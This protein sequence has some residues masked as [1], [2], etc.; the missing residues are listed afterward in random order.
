L[1]PS[2]SQAP[3]DNGPIRIGEIATMVTDGRL[4]IRTKPG[5]G[6]DS[7][8]Y[9]TKIFPGQRVLIIEGPVEASGYP[10]FRVRLGAIEGWVA[11]AGQD[12]GPWLAP[13]RNGLIAFVRDAADGS[14][15]AIYTIAPNATSG[16]TL[17]LADSSVID[18]SQL[19]WS[20]DGRRLAFVGTPAD[21]VN[22][23]SE[24]FVVDVDGSNL[25]QITH[26]EVDA[27]DPAWSPD[28]T[29]IAVRQNVTDPS[30]PD[31]S[32]VV[33]IRAD[34]SG[35]KVLGPGGNPVWSPDGEQLAMTVS[36]GGSSHIW[37]QS[38]DGGNRRQVT[39]V[40]V[41]SA[42]S[43]WSP[44]GQSLV[45]SSLGLFLVDLASGSI[46]PVA[47]LGWAPTWSPGGTIAFVTP[48]SA[49]PGVFAVES[50][51]TGLKR[52]SGDPGPFAVPTWSPD[53]RRLL[54]AD[55]GVRG[56]SIAIV[57]PASGTLTSIADDGTS[58]SPAW[59]PRLP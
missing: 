41:A 8:V 20:P 2:A 11:A 38:A 48:G 36:D 28:S 17:L 21:S 16:E 47:E 43:A 44:D 15:E 53:G 9:K 1:T 30:V 58:G 19:T 13:V 37:V 31:G 23:A 10:W 59:Q 24:I 33:V 22:G 32:N 27:F 34:G 46:A 40:A 5:R 42:R 56:S 29:R 18:Y 14:G 50:D 57:D 54:V 26:D 49:S 7:A 4:V 39:D 35:V 55:E 3:D 12:G 52:V 45:F 25:V 6:A 51:G